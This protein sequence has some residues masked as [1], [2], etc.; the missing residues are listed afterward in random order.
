[1]E[2]I[3]ARICAFIHELVGV[4]VEDITPEST[5]AQ[6]HMDSLDMQELVLELEDEY[7]VIIDDGSCSTI[8]EL[9]DQVKAA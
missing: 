4:P 1:M 3:F 8:N 5:P 6:L 9:I 7:D 2:N